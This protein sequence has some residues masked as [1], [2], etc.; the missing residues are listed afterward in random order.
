MEEE[1]L[2]TSPS[3]VVRLRLA[4]L[5][6]ESSMAIV[7]RRLFT[8][9]YPPVDEDVAIMALIAAAAPDIVDLE[10]FHPSCWLVGWFWLSRVWVDGW[11]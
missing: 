3:L 11:I 6:L 10:C 1:R 9:Q 5:E 4:R 7:L 8:A 2:S